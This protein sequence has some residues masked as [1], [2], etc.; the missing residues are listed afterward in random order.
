ML[1]Y[2]GP[3]CQHIEGMRSNTTHATLPLSCVLFPFL[4]S[5]CTSI[6]LNCC[7][8]NTK[9]W[10]VLGSAH[11]CVDFP[12]F[13][14]QN[15]TG[16]NSWCMVGEILSLLGLQYPVII[17]FFPCKM[18]L[19]QAEGLLLLWLGHI[20]TPLTLGSAVLPVQN[21]RRVLLLHLAEHREHIRQNP[22]S[23]LPNFLMYP[24]SLI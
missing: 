4:P 15:M 24:L 6:K 18:E 21:G 22:W 23:R 2:E 1:Y 20:L 8:S 12:A 10:K 5:L 16:E 17:Y 7:C 9:T 3:I 14:R 19:K 11:K 13:P